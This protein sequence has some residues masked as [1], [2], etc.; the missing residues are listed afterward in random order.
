MPIGQ[1]AYHTPFCQEQYLE[2][3]LHGLEQDLK[4]VSMVV[5]VKDAARGGNQLVNRGRESCL[6]SEG[7]IFPPWFFPPPP[8]YK[9]PRLF[10]S[11][12]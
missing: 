7:E 1:G 6:T 8:H 2:E 10:H 5:D 11:R 4:R 9:F 3:A 12:F